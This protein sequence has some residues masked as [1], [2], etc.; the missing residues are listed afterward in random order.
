MARVKIEEARNTYLQLGTLATDSK[1]KRGLQLQKH[2]ATALRE[3]LLQIGLGMILL[4]IPELPIKRR[5]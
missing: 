3:L 2:S 5:L 1:L 4:A